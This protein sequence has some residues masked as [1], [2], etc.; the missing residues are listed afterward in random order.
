MFKQWNKKL[1]AAHLADV[2]CW[3]TLGIIIGAYCL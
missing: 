1:L 2:A 3:F